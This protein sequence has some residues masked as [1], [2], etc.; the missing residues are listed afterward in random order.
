MS[1]IK[2][3]DLVLVVRPKLCCGQVTGYLGSCIYKVS[4][5]VQGESNCSYCGAR[6][7]GS[8]SRVK[9]I[10]EDNPIGFYIE[11]LK[12]IEPLSDPETTKKHEELKV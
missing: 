11:R 1:N 2:V 10:G 8:P 6:C 3:G 5:L 4:G 12:K 9:A 7:S